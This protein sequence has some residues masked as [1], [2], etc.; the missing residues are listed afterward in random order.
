MGLNTIRVNNTDTNYVHSIFDISEYNS[1]ATYSDL[2]SALAAVPQ[3]KQKGGMGVRYVQEDSDNNRKYVQ[4]FLEKNSWSTNTTDWVGIDE[5][6]TRNSN[7]LV[8]SGEV[9]KSINAATDEIFS[10]VVP[11]Q[12]DCFYFGDSSVNV[13]C[14][15][16]STGVDAKQY[17]I[18]DENGNVLNIITSDF[19]NNLLDVSDIEDSL[20]SDSSTMTLSAK[21]GKTLYEYIKSITS[22]TK[23]IEPYLNSVRI[24]ESD[25]FQF[26]DSSGNIVFKIDESAAYISGGIKLYNNNTQTSEIRYVDSYED[27]FS[28]SDGEGN[29]VAKIDSTGIDANNFGTNL[30]NILSTMIGSQKTI[31]CWGDSLTAGAGAG[32]TTELS[33]STKASVCSKFVSMGYPDWSERASTNY[34]QMIQLLVGESYNVINCGVGGESLIS[35]G[36]RQG[37]LMAVL[38]SSYTLPANATEV[39]IGESLVSSFDRT[40]LVKVLLQGDGNS[41]NTC[42]VQGIPCTLRVTFNSGY[43]NVQYYLKRKTVGDRDVVLPQWTPIVMRGS[44]YAP[45]TGITVLW[46]WQNGGYSS[47]DDLISKLDNIV[48]HIE[49]SK[50]IVIGLHSGNLSNRNE[51]EA[52][53]EKHFGDKFFNWRQ[54]ASTNALYDFGVTVTTSDTSAMTSGSMPPS[55]LTDSVH[56][57]SGGY[58]ILG[59]KIWERMNQLG[60][61]D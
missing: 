18:L 51:Q 47:N 48:S 54:Y 22:Y 28:F 30:T 38:N 44:S 36:A 15:I 27:S 56:M 10:Y 14:K 33:L 26:S 46:C 13:I 6:V 23:N 20:T 16:K 32:S 59:Y 21:Q 11:T 4:Y 61:F 3:E 57:N 37:G 7:N 58:M 8:K 12:D 29:V 34:V 55:L 42:Y 53:L 2:S 41:V 52:A 25:A 24:D 31:V 40:S 60:Y 50:Y 45:K 19:L 9:Y 17:N 35:I 39:N 43:T 1:G 49:N 5:K